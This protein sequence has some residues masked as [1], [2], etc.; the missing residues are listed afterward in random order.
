MT[1]PGNVRNGSKTGSGQPHS[2][3]SSA[4]TRIDGRNTQAE[5]LGGLQIYPEFE[6]S[7]LLNRK[8]GGFRALDDLVDVAFKQRPE[9]GAGA[10]RFAALS[11]RLRRGLDTA[12][13]SKS[14]RIRRVA[15]AG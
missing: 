4:R 8:I 5:R 11:R 15:G 13:V 2:I 1:S 9:I 10:L 14:D 12:T 3:T 6:L 7:R